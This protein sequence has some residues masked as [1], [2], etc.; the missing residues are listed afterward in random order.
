MDLLLIKIAVSVVSAIITT[1]AVCLVSTVESKNKEKKSEQKVK[2]GEDDQE[3]EKKEDGQEAE[4]D[5]DDFSN[6]EC[7]IILSVIFS[8]IIFFLSLISMCLLVASAAAS[9]CALIVALIAFVKESDDIGHSSFAFAGV[10]FVVILIFLGVIFFSYNPV[11]SENQ[12]VLVDKINLI[13]IA[14]NTMVS[15]EFYLLSGQID[16]TRI[17]EYYYELP[18]GGSLYGNI[19]ASAIP[20]FEEYR[21]DGYIGKFQLRDQKRWP[22]LY[23]VLYGV[24]AEEYTT[25]CSF[26]ELHVPTGTIKRD[27]NI[28]L[29]S[30]K[31]RA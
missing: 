20:V 3:A 14:D 22:E 19:A 4:K 27:M 24:P 16:T 29:S 13:A 12:K 8:I 5:D 28:D 1:L 18:S 26:Q 11:V 2:E 25:K 10:I 15:G 6:R 17:Y 30:S 23:Q 21:S 7:T 31:A 9:I